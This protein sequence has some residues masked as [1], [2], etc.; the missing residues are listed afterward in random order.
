MYDDREGPFIPGTGPCPRVFFDMS[1]GGNP[2]GRIV[3]K[4]YSDVVPKTAENFRALCTGT[5]GRCPHFCG[6]SYP[7]GLCGDGVVTWSPVD[8]GCRPGNG[9]ANSARRRAVC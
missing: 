8:T 4:L 1:I 6:V 3:F 2:V 5:A 9:Q 7:H